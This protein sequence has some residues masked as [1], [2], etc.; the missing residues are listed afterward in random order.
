MKKQKTKKKFF[1]KNKVL[2]NI[3]CLSERKILANDAKLIDIDNNGLHFE[4]KKKEMSDIFKSSAKKDFL[5][6]RVSLV[7]TGYECRLEGIIKD[8]HQVKEDSFEIHV[9]YTE[10]T[11]KFYRECVNQ[12]IS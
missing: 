5:D 6:H 12:L 9:G 1:Q 8:I 3:V 4:L 7:L 10:D 11:P 2:S